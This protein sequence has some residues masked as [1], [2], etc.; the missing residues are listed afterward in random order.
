MKVRKDIQAVAAQVQSQSSCQC[1]R[2]LLVILYEILPTTILPRFA[3]AL[4]MLAEITCP[5]T[6]YP[7]PTARIS[8][9]KSTEALFWTTPQKQPF[10]MSLIPHIVR[11]DVSFLKSVKIY[12]LPSLGLC[13]ESPPERFRWCRFS[14]TFLLASRSIVN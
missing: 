9:P 2:P 3:T 8:R 11:S 5:S 14:S 6:T 1:S 10:R 13:E 7:A 12:L 4:D